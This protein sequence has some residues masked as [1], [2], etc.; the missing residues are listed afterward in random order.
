MA[1]IETALR[2]LESGCWRQAEAESRVVSTAAPDDPHARLLTGLAIAAMGEAERAAPVLTAVAAARPEADH[3]CD[4]LLALRPALPA[5]LAA[6]QFRACLELA[7]SDHRLRR[8]FARFLLDADDPA[9]AEALLADMP[10]DAAA[11]HLKGLARADQ[12]RYPLAISSFKIAVALNPLAAASW[13]NLG[14][15]LKIEGDLQKAIGAH[16]RA[17]TLEPGNP[18]FRMNRAVALLQAGLW[19]QAWQDYEYRMDLAA[20]PLLDRSRVL[21]SLSDGVR[22]AGQTVLALH[23]QGFG[24]TLQ[25]MRYLPLLADLGARVVACVPPELARV[26][27]LVPGVAEVVCDRGDL[28]PHD[29]M[30][31]MDSLP[32]VFGTTLGTIPPVP[33]IDWPF[34]ASSHHGPACPGHLSP[35]VL[36]GVART[37]RAMT[38]EARAMTREARTITVGDAGAPLRPARRIGLVWAGQARPSEPRFAPLDRRRSAGLAA[39]APLAALSGVEFV[40]LQMGPAARQPAPSGLVL[41]DPMAGVTDFLDTAAIIA[42]LD[43]VVSVDT[44]VVHLA[45]LVGTPVM[46]LDRYDG[47]WRWL[48]GRSDSPWYPRLRIFRQEQPGDWSVPMA[49][50]A[51]ALAAETVFSEIVTD[52]A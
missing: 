45:G 39:F 29:F 11:H 23:D 21:P 38:R 19:E 41:T 40:S 33:D 25:F 3:P 35:Q 5:A 1:S 37:S 46:L 7:P 34:A 27:R 2:L 13:S 18:R 47:C 49:R 36:A 15:V 9:A 8:A 12:Q 10:G 32:R 48:H 52:L 6:R 51:A 16:D 4:D 22:L 31:P 17:V 26:V 20:A 50:I 42:G 28:P 44:S 24:D 43:A 14:I 30:C